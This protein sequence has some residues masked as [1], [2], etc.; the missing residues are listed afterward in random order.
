MLASR[1]GNACVTLGCPLGDPRVSQTQT[2]SQAQQA[3][4]RALFSIYPITKLRIYQFLPG[5]RE[6]EQSSEL[7]SFQRA[8]LETSPLGAA[9]L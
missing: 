1:L 4:G 9:I 8:C 7:F 6:P 3:E 5:Y 2:Q